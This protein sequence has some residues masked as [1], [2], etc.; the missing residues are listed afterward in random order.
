M[1]QTVHTIKLKLYQF[2]DNFNN[3]FASNAPCTFHYHCHALNVC[4]F[5][6]HLTLVFLWLLTIVSRPFRS[7]I[8]FF[9]V[10]FQ[11]VIYMYTE[12]Y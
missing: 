6:S 8:F 4:L 1:R 7:T 10:S 9:H 3:N 11:P 5:P 12:K 2:L